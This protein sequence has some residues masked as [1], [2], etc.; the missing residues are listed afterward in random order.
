MGQMRTFPDA[1][2]LYRAAAEDF[3][4]L[5]GE[6]VRRAGRF[7]VALA[8]GSTPRRLYELLAADS[9]RDRVA[10]GRVELF[11]GDERAVPADHPDSNYGSAMEALATLPL[12]P[13]RVHRIRVEAA[14]LPQ[15]ARDYQIEIARVHG[16]SPEGV[17]PALDLVL[18]GM[19]ADGH[20]ASLFPG[21]E[22][23]G[24]RRRWVV[25][26]FVAHR[27]TRRITLTAPIINRA[28]NIRMLVMGADKAPALSAVLSGPR[29]PARLPAQ[30]VMPEDGTL[31]WLVDQILADGLGSETP[32]IPGLGPTPGPGIIGPTRDSP[33]RREQRHA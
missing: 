17:P 33:E 32:A 24:E 14:N 7:T 30:L 8:G 1:E 9:Y 16:A 6:A 12:S 20:T 15:A 10:W 29:D 19:G 23:V 25:S 27:G 5:A 13:E 18:L 31:I 21:S 22:A 3:L 2:T 4:D 26:D 28:R 11:W